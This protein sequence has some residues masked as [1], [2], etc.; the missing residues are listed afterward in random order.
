MSGAEAFGTL[1]DGTP[2]HKVTIRAG[3]LTA[4]FLDY[5]ARLIA[6]HLPGIGH[7][8]TTGSDRMEDYL[9]PL[10]YHGALVAPVVNRLSGATATIAGRAYRFEANQNGHITLHSGAAGTWG[11]VWQIA[12]SGP[13]HVV[14]A[15]HLPDGEG[16]FPG[17][18]RIEA[19]FEAEAPATLRM[20]LTATTDAPTLMNCANHSYW[21]MDGG[22]TWDGHTLQVLADRVTETTDEDAPT[23]RVLP[24]E[25]LGLDLRQGRLLDVETFRVD[26]NFCLSDAPG[27]LREAAHLTGRNGV[28]LTVATT[29]PGLQ[30]FDN[31]T[32]VRPGC[33]PYEAIAIEA[34][35]W[36]DAPN[37]DGFPSI[38]LAPGET[39]RTVTEWRFSR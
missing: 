37:Q 12:E 1:A 6:V 15:I 30:F 26:H 7:S 18:R 23:G 20:T 38:A 33:V 24:V 13:S 5:G 35:N 17:N 8:L 3:E 36:P 16:G 27:P 21:T 10:L 2:V 29:E 22:E 32:S 9:G 31:R 14:F 11:K 28:R 25:E 19:R 34:Q 39:Y 4:S